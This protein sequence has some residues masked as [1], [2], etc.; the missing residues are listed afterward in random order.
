[1]SHAAT[2]PYPERQ[3]PADPWVWGRPIFAVLCSLLVGAIVVFTD[4]NVAAAA[5]PPIAIG[6]LLALVIEPRRA[7]SILLFG[8]LMFE[9][10]QI[11]GLDAPVTLQI[12]FFENFNNSIGVP[13]PTNPVE[14]LIGLMAVTHLFTMLVTRRRGFTW[15]PFM[16]PVALIGLMLA[17]FMALGIAKGGPINI[18]LW[19]VRALF[20]MVATFFVG[21]QLVKTYRDVVINTWMILIP[22]AIK[23]FQGV[24]RYYVDLGGDIGD[25]PAITSHECAVFIMTVF[26]LTAGLLFFRGQMVMV[27]F[28]LVTFPTTAFTFY[29]SMRRVAYGA[30]VFG[31]IILFLFLPRWQKLFFV[32]L[33]APLV[34]MVALYFAVFWNTPTGPGMPVQLVRSI[35][36]EDASGQEDSSNTYR[37]DEKINLVH[38][39]RTYPLGSGF[40]QKYLIVKHMDEVD[41]PLWDYIPHNCILW[42][43]CKTGMFGIT[44]FFASVA[45]I[46]IQCMIDFRTSVR[47]LYKALLI[48]LI[49]FWVNQVIVAYY[50]LQLTFY[51]NMVY[52][53]A[54]MALMVPIH[55]EARRRAALAPSE[56]RPCP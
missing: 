18:A 29:W 25:V 6:G 39:I 17:F 54:F 34:P 27:A 15:H 49:V 31:I 30:V 28:N 7:F 45:L 21:S 47:P 38:T 44:T 42:M 13:L 20:L 16:L 23:G 56:A 2:A 40:G 55:Q 9:Q 51:R 22:M 1:M 5:A 26:I 3:L 53:G 46:I 43:W 48:V 19:E 50:D 35:F 52:M 8:A 33:V 41:F 10:Y 11:F 36:G 32:K 24:W 37:D 4:G 14:C 12:P